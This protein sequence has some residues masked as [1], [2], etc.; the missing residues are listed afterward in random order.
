MVIWCLTYSTEPLSEQ[1]RKPAATTA[2]T[3]LISSNRSFICIISDN[4]AQYSTLLY[5]SWNTG[6]NKKMLNE[7]T[8]KDWSDDPL[9]HEQT[10]Y[11]GAASPKWTQVYY[12]WSYTTHHYL[13]CTLRLYKLA[14]LRCHKYFSNHSLH[15]HIF[16]KKYFKKSN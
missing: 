9:H 4:I 3:T 1:E 6:W 12:L 16:M 5:Q 8:M 2:W 15:R 13:D 7:S 10:L 14:K 11:H